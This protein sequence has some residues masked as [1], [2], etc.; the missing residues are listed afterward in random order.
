[1]DDYHAFNRTKVSSGGGGCFPWK[2]ILIIAV[3]CEFITLYGK[4][5]G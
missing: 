3:L 5:S 4:C 1:M 2:A